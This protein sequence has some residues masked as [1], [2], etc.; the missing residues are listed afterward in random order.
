M[1]KVFLLAVLIAIYSCEPKE[2]VS[3]IITDSVQT[4]SLEYNDQTYTVSVDKDGNIDY[5]N[6]SVELSNIIE[7]TNSVQFKGNFYHF[8]TVEEMNTLL[9]TIKAQQPVLKTK[10]DDSGEAKYIAFKHSNYVGR[11]ITRTGESEIGYL[12]DLDFNDV[13]SSALVVNRTKKLYVI[14][15]FK[16]SYFEGKVKAIVLDPGKV[17]RLPSFKQDRLNDEISSIKTWFF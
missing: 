16:H 7:S 10:I 4:S 12:T 5:A 14:Q 3:D 1:K 6:L 15:F 2:A 8:D 13:I 9:T 11:S 17:S